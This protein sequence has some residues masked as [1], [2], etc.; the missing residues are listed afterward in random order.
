MAEP[1]YTE[2]GIVAPDDIV[3]PS[4]APLRNV[5]D[6]VTRLRLMA[7]QVPGITYHDLPPA[8]TLA[9]AADEIERLRAEQKAFVVRPDDWLVIVLPEDVTPEL[10]EII[11]NKIDAPLRCHTLMLANL[12]ARRG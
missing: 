7:G 12:E 5:G 6:I 8:S 10:A 1:I 11:R 9:D 3:Q 4:Q 2:T